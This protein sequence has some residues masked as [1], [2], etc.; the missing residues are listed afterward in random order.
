MLLWGNGWGM[1]NRCTKA[2]LYKENLEYNLNQ[3]RKYVKK[4]VKLCVAVKA[5]G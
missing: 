5:D 3:I 2:I 4:E 1:Y